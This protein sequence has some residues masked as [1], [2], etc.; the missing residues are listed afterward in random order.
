MLDQYD[1]LAYNRRNPLLKDTK[2]EH[3]GAFVKSYYLE[4]KENGNSVCN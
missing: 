3:K 1:E 4:E 2:G